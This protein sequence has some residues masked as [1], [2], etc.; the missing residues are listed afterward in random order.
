MQQIAYF[1]QIVAGAEN[2]Q[3]VSGMSYTAC[4]PFALSNTATVAYAIPAFSDWLM[5][6]PF[7]AN[8]V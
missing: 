3:G 1:S 5:A 2:T 7:S 4:G 8:A 6:E